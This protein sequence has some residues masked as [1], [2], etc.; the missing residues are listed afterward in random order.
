MKYSISSRILLKTGDS[1][2]RN[3]SFQSVKTITGEGRV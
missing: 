2:I 1:M 3:G